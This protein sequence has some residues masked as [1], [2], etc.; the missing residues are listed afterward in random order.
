MNAPIFR[1]GTLELIGNTPLV[2]LQRLCPN[3]KV[4][5]WV[6][7][8]GHNPGG[9]VKD[10]I[11]LSMIEAA[12]RGGV[13][14]K[15]K[16]ILEATSGNTGIGLALVGACKGYKVMLAMSEA[17][18]QERRQILG[19]LGAEFLLTPPHL[20]TDGAI[21]VVY[22]L[23]RREPGKYFIADQYNNP[24]NPAA[25]QSGTAQEIWAQTEGRI[26][27][28]VAAM[29]TSGTLMGTSL[30]LKQHRPD[31]RIIGV[32]PYLGHKI[33]GLKNLKEAYRPGIFERSRLDDKINVAD[34]DAFAATRLLAREEGLFVGMSSGAAL[35]AALELAVSLESGVIVT[36]LAD[37][38]ERYLSTPLFGL[39]APS[40]KREMKL[41]LY[42]TLCRA[43][44]TFE[45]LS[46]GKVSMYTCGPTVNASPTL[47][48]LRRVLVTDV[49]RRY[50]ERC[51]LEVRHVMN[52]TDLDDKTIA[53]SLRRGISVKQLTSEVADEFLATLDALSVKRAWKYPRA[54]AHVDD[55]VALT[56]KLIDKGVAYEKLR[57]VYFDIGK[58]PQYGSLSGLDM[59]KIR[60][61]TTVDLDEYE[62][63][64]PRDFTLLKRATLAE[65][66]RDIF[67]ETE[68]GNVRPG[69]HIECATM[70]TRYLGEQFDIH[71]SSTDLVFPHNENEIA[72]CEA[73]YGKGPAR[74]WVHS[75]IVLADGKKMS[76]STG[77]AVT[78]AD[79]EALGFCARDVRFA[80]LSTHY[81]SP[82]LYSK[83]KL[84][85]ARATL[86][87]LDGFLVRLRAAS[88]SAQEAQVTQGEE[89]TPDIDLAALLQ[90]DFDAALD[91][92]LNV[93]KA[94]GA[95]FAL[96]RKVNPVLLRGA[97]PSDRAQKLLNVLRRLD[98][99]LSFLNVDATLVARPED[100]EVEVLVQRRDEA[101]ERK[102]YAEADRLREELRRRGISLEDGAHVTAWWRCEN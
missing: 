1:S 10:R 99:V 16:T 44:R 60:L 81:R 7:L 70:S 57:S 94:M 17:V 36:L 86:R 52:I 66:S 35:H 31:I 40:A 51:G 41:E 26:T 97:L 30:G 22:R 74:F 77:N 48:L 55:M 34:A 33:Q 91:S 90:A 69:L 88:T 54:S 102:D 100:P 93:P 11:A 85:A 98:D 75:E 42:D 5:L 59:T 64:N 21:E 65:M 28:F 15:D 92:D 2:R 37:G 82:L 43:R 58:L 8:E 27:H 96:V 19:A 20:G 39:C 14:T 53:E 84:A 80:L 23:V 13:L 50:L 73:L 78:L 95:V 6:K 83:T 46:P 71:T 87:R 32:E 68:W 62:K 18:S 101:R 79:I 47:A 63:D 72:Q 76:R 24:A 3:P 25:H 45:P 29:G 49:L 89:S 4:E 38:G 67:Y 56:R 9:S 12:E 61:G